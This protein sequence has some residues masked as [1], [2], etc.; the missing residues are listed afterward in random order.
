MDSMIPNAFFYGPKTGDRF[1]G[2]HLGLLKYLTTDDQLA[3]F[4]G[5]ELEHGLSVLDPQ[6]TDESNIHDRLLKRVVENE[7]DAKSV[8]NRVH[9][10]GMN[11][12]GALEALGILKTTSGDDISE[13]HT[14]TSNRMN[15]MEQEL[16]GMTRIIGERINQSDTTEITVPSLRAFLGSDEFLQKRKNTVER[17]MSSYKE[18]INHLLDEIKNL[19]SVSE[20]DLESATTKVGDEFG[21][22]KSLF[23]RNKDI[24]DE[25][26]YGIVSD[27]ELLDYELRYESAFAKD[28]FEGITWVFGN[29]M[30]IKVTVQFEII[31]NIMTMDIFNNPLMTAHS[32]TTALADID[33]KI[34]DEQKYTGTSEQEQS[35]RRIT[36]ERNLEKLRSRRQVLESGLEDLPTAERVSAKAGEIDTSIPVC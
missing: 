17:S 30:D 29:D 24:V 9:A 22:I 15:T 7:V 32:E 14:M 4:L 16:T 10:N 18:Q 3:W 31:Y 23:S 11:P 27:T 20:D 8:F 26:L 33:K 36:I 12:Y 5:H 19:E 2:I 13:T 21:K 1:V 25:Q 34:A 28:L 6:M 35:S